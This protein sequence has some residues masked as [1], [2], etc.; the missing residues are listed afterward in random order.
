MRRLSVVQWL[1]LG[2]AL[3]TL[4]AC[5]GGGVTGG[6]ANV[7][8]DTA[9]TYRAAFTRAD[10][11]LV[12]YSDGDGAATAVITDSE[13]V[14]QS[15]EGTVLTNGRFQI[16][17]A[18]R[19]GFAT[20]EGTLSKE[21]GLEARLV[22]GVQ[23]SGISG[24]RVAT[25]AQHV[26]QGSYSATLVGGGS[27]SFTVAAD[28]SVT[29]T[30]TLGLDTYWLGGTVSPVGRISIT[31]GMEAMAPGSLRQTGD[32]FFIGST[33]RVLGAWNVEGTS[34]GGVMDSSPQ[35]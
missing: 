4:L 24:T 12:F 31:G 22:G 3:L 26:F 35:Q 15:G 28:G 30:S 23:L 6:N 18:G 19:G 9:G 2:V 10:Y 32:V 21:L 29:G 16:P 5:G 25:T 14:H 20:L 11:V 27:T 17:M 8:R 33:R 7:R 13:G 34:L 1:A